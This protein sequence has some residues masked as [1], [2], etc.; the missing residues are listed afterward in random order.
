[1]LNFD[2]QVPKTMQNSSVD[3]RNEDNAN[4]AINTQEMHESPT[5]RP[6]MHDLKCSKIHSII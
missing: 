6:N 5:L 2:S 1:M 4:N 3:I